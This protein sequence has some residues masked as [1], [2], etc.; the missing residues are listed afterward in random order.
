[1]AASLI[2][3]IENYLHATDTQASLFGPVSAKSVSA[4]ASPKIIPRLQPRLYIS[5]DAIPHANVERELRLS[6]M[7]LTNND[8]KICTYRE[9]PWASATFIGARH[10]WTLEIKGEDHAHI[11]SD[12]EAT[13]RD[14]EF[15]IR[16][17]IVADAIM[18]SRR[19]NVDENNE[20]GT[21]V[22]LEILTI[23]DD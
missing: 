15:S 12:L 3:H 18:T 2:R 5:S 10:Y 11:A 23:E 20:A 21:I 8:T 4:K 13:I 1:M 16:G 17:H 6:L 22:T 9:R 19:E 7:A 14:H